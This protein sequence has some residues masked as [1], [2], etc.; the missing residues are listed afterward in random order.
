MSCAAGSH[1]GSHAD[2]RPSGTPDLYGQPTAARPRSRTDLNG[3]GRPYIIFRVR[4]LGVRVPPSA[5]QF[6]QLDGPVISRPGRLSRL[7]AGFWPYRRRWPRR[8]R[9]GRRLCLALSRGGRCR[10]RR[11]T[12]GGCPRYR[13]AGGCSPSRRSPAPRLADQCGWPV[14]RCRRLFR[15]ESTP[16]RALPLVASATAH[17]PRR[18]RLRTPTANPL[19]PIR[20]DGAERGAAIRVMRCWIDG[21]AALVH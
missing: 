17:K 21:E 6:P 3:S 1:A 4:R 20:L 8:P 18:P 13:L 19:A 14:Q 2:E 12:P 11:P 16:S 9:P 15:H 10:A 7:L 5:P